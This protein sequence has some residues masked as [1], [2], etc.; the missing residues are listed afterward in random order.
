MNV[1]KSVD[2]IIGNTPLLELV[3]IQ[4]E[5]GLKAKIFAKLEYLNPAGSVKDRVAKSMLDDAESKGLITEGATI[6]EPTSGNTGI[7]LASIGA[8]RGYK[9]ILTMPDTM[10]KER[11]KLLKAYGAQVVL[12]EG[13][14]GM[15][16]AIDKA[17]ELNKSIANSFIPSQFSNCANPKA[18][19]Q[20]TANEIWQ[21]MDGNVDIFVATIG[22]SGT[23]S[24]T[25][26]RLKEL[27]PMI[28]VVGVEPQSSPLISKGY[29]GAHKIQGIGANFI[30]KNLDLSVI[31]K[32]LTAS[33]N[34]AYYYANLVAKK[35][36][37]LVGISSGA[38]LSVAVSLAKLDEFANKN[39]VV[40]FPD[41]GDRYLST[42][43]YGE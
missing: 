37:V 30:P 23:I 38:G 34:D 35:Q 22:S 4:K 27:D 17:E 18:H 26:K 16:G 33:D 32:V 36:G 28:Q 9:V 40:I 31:D 29:S 3:N 10:S 41:A 24:G 15:Q 1:Y 11:I 6:I 39:I 25:A 5:L 43:L 14:L 8:S 7:G 20:A 12:T 21:D 13:A 2:Q 19:Y 42:D